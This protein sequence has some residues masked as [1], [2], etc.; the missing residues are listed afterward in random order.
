MTTT[1]DK[2]ANTVFQL[3][4]SL[5]TLTVL[6]LLKFDLTALQE[7]LTQAIKQAP[8]FFQNMPI[9]IDLQ[10]LAAG[11]A[12]LDFSSLVNCLRAQG[13]S[14]LGVRGGNPAQQQAALEANLAVFPT[15]KTEPLELA[16]QIT[17]AEKISATPTPAQTKA[18]VVHTTKIITQPVRS[19]QQIYA[20]NTDLVV[21]ASVS[22][23]AELIADGNIHV[24]GPLRGRALAGVAGNEEAQIFCQSLE[25]ELVAIAGHYWVNEDIQS[26]PV[27]ENV[28]IYLENDRLQISEL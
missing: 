27:K 18:P 2:N 14:P 4:G 10:K 9:V 20:R 11:A 5:F 17:K 22:A 21:L 23:G 24:Y 19:G 16:P 1:S 26:K 25:A 3:K 15:T 8:K 6:H 7:Q 12:Q 13:L 28:H